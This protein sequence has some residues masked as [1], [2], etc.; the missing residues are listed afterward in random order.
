[1]DKLSPLSLRIPPHAYLPYAI[2]YDMFAL[3]GLRVPSTRP[4]LYSLRANKRNYMCT[5]K[6]SVY[7]FRITG[8][9]GVKVIV[10]I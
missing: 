1:M 5:Y 7:V 3:K 2:V 8:N 9:K 6:L 4:T 10:S